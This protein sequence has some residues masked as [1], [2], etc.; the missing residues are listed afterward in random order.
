MNKTKIGISS[1]SYSYA[2]GFPGFQPDKP[3]DAFGLVKKAIDLKVSVVQI[4]DNCPL[5]RLSDEQ[6]NQLYE[7]AASNGIELEVGTRGIQTAHLTRYIEIAKRLHSSL[8]RVVIDTKDH[9]PEFDEIIDLLKAVMPLLEENGIV[10]GIENHDRFKT[11]VWKKIIDTMNSPFVGIVLD[12]VNSFSCEENSEQVLNALGKY[13]VN[14]HVKDYRIGRIP[15]SMG[16]MVTGT[17]AGQGFLNIPY[18]A[19]TI[20]RNAR[21]DYSSILEL[22]MPCEPTVEETLKKE[23]FWVEQSID[24]LKSVLCTQEK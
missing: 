24:Y 18:M 20:G 19:E 11:D 5:D 14:L 15:N 6:L 17:I 10:L 13:T 4:A 3:L 1:Y 16:L 8:L 2:V 23:N 21:G 12:T 7:Y 22:W 9:E